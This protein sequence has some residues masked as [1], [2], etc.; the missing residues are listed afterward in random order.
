V[1]QELDA[2]ADSGGFANSG[3]DTADAVA[4]A[5]LREDEWRRDG[6]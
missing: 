2:K 3:I 6:V 5:S 4:I 1:A